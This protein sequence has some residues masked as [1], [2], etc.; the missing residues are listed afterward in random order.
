MDPVISDP[1]DKLILNNRLIYKKNVY[2]PRVKISNWF[3]SAESLPI[4]TDPYCAGSQDYSLS[5][6]KR[7]GTD[8][9]EPFI[10][11]TQAMLEQIYRKNVDKYNMPQRKYMVN[12]F[13]YSE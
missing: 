3:E 12:Y 1:K 9:D 8:T 5:H 13:G 7:L 4:D 11:T 2:D 10:T 6:Y